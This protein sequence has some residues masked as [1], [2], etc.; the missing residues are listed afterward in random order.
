MKFTITLELHEVA[1]LLRALKMVPRTGDWYSSIVSKIADSVNE[2]GVTKEDVDKKAN[3]MTP[4]QVRR[5]LDLMEFKE[6]HNMS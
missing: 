4:K 2:S 6:K 5:H 1:N 3:L